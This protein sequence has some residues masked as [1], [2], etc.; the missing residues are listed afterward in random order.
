M[1]LI[2]SA[3]AF[4]NWYLLLVNTLIKI[5]TEGNFLNMIKSIYEKTSTANIILN[6]EILSTVLLSS[7]RLLGGML[8]PILCDIACKVLASVI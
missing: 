4:D 6:C 5:V 1:I 3:K 2:S 7:R 8:S